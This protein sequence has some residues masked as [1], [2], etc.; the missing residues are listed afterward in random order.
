MGKQ[1]AVIGAGNGGTAIAGDLTLAGHTCRVFE[2]EDWAE[3]VTAISARGGIQVT[4]VAHTGFAKVALATTNI[5]AA[6]EGADLIMVATQA[7]THTRVART[8][9]PV[10]AAGQVII[11]WPGSGGTLEC[12]RVFDELGVTADVILAEA[13][14]FPYCCRRLQ[15]PGTV[16]IHRIDGPRNQI[17]ALPASR[18]PALMRALDG[19]YDTVAPARSILEPALYNPN[20]IVHPAGALFNMGRIEYSRGDFWMY[21]EGITPS[22]KKIITHMDHEC[23]ALMTALG[24]PPKTYDEVFHDLF[25]ITVEEF[26]VASSKGPFSMQ[27]RYISE[28]VPMGVTLTASLGRLLGVPT[29]TYDAIIHIASVVNETAYFSA[30]RTLANLKLGSFSATELQEYVMTGNRPAA[31]RS[32][33]Q[34][35]S[36]SPKAKGRAKATPAVKARAKSRRQSPKAKAAKKAKR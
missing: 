7:L 18:T 21:K 1:I 5:R 27:D 13:A 8:L 10:V 15:G 9:A 16:N 26:A 23:Q 35:V 25:G 17:A 31:R 22:V 32:T 28:D 11:F 33:R 34:R 4:G 6:V 3:N 36:A 20:L 12:R 30:G 14:T 19:V 29:P 2:F 24:Y